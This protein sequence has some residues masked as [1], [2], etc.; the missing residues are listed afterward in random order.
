MRKILLAK[1]SFYPGLKNYS[2]QETKL[3]NLA[4]L[5]EGTYGKQVGH[6]IEFNENTPSCKRCFLFRFEKRF[7]SGNKTCASKTV[8]QCKKCSDR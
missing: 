5:Q 2:H 4:I 8:N 6:S 1:D 3:N 7:S